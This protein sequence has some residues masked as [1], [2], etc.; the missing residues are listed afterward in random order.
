VTD[1]GFWFVRKRFGLGATPVTW[2]GFALTAGYVVLLVADLQETTTP[3]PRRIIAGALTIGFL[4]IAAHK[5]DGGLGWQWG[6]RSD[7]S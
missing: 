3:W 1:S 7:R 2:Q 6:R 5:T 4:V